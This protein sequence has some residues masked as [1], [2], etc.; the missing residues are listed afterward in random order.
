MTQPTRK[1]KQIS[2]DIKFAIIKQ[3]NN[4]MRPVEIEKLYE[5]TS[6]TVSTII[7]NK[8]KIVKEYENNRPNNRY[9]PESRVH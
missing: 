2:L 3:H 9:R 1:R 4:C 7:K 6:S 8:D 5:Y